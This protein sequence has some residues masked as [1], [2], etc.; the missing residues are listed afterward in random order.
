MKPYLGPEA[1]EGICKIFY[2]NNGQ[3][4]YCL[5]VTFI[6][7]EKEYWEHVRTSV[8]ISAS[9]LVIHLQLPRRSKQVPLRME[10]ASLTY[11]QLSESTEKPP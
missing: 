11:H 7:S 1:A 6:F 2:N 10:C 3:E 9:P 5:L 4:V 8:S